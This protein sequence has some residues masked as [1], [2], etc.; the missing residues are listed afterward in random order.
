MLQPP[1]LTF[2]LCPIEWWIKEVSLYVRMYIHTVNSQL[3]NTLTTLLFVASDALFEGLDLVG[4][5][6]ESRGDTG[7][8]QDTVALL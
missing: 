8:C 7:V 2:P 3:E 6:L 5:S 4:Q 1:N